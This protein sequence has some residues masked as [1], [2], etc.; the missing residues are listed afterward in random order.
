MEEDEF[1]RRRNGCTIFLG[2][3]S[4]MVSSGV[5]ETLRFLAQHRLV[6]CIV[7][8][9]GG[10]E[11]DL[12]KCLAPTRVGEFSLAGAG[13]RSAGVNRTGN[14]LVPNENYCRFQDWLMPLLDE[15]A[16]EARVDGAEWT[17]SALVQRLGERI[18]SRS[19][20]C[21]WAAVNRIPVFCPA[22]TDG[23]LGDMLSLHSFR[24]GSLRVDVVRDVR[25]IS[26]VALKATRAGI[27]VAGG[28]TVKHHIANACLM[29]NG[30]DYAVLLNS[31]ADFDGSDSGASPDEAVSWG[32]VRPD[33]H[34]V[35]VTADAS[36]TLPLLVAQS[37][38][39]Y[40]ATR[41][42]DPH[43]TT[44]PTTTTRDP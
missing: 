7:T 5:R 43:A 12:I 30:A 21:H 29:R 34:P 31:Q 9:A 35:K 18:G 23:S 17:P 22:L 13:L 16:E 27:L 41:R 8:T 15:M 44:Q 39:P 20:L 3:T 33:A 11:E 37:F 19:S 6:D 36:L 24:G 32:K 4:N 28:G 14:L 1:I 42:P 10:V 38:A 2:F 25:R 26:S 40:H